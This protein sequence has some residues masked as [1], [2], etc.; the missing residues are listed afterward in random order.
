[1]TH[2]FYLFL[3]LFFLLVPFLFLFF[4]SV[5]FQMLGTAPPI[6]WSTADHRKCLY[7]SGSEKWVLF[8]FFSSFSLLS[9]ISVGYSIVC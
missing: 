2:F 7:A 5:S 9:F 6:L 3:L 4:F 8:P 1:M